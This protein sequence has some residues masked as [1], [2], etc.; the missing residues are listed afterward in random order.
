[1]TCK[2]LISLLLIVIPLLGFVPR[3]NSQSF[4]TIT[5]SNTLTS[6]ISTT[7]A[8]VSASG[9]VFVTVATET[10]VY[11]NSFTMSGLGALGERFCNANYVGPIYETAGQELVGSISAIGFINFYIMNDK[12]FRAYKSG[13]SCMPSQAEGALYSDENI[14]SVPLH[15]TAPYNGNYYFLFTTTSANDVTVALNV[16]STVNSTTSYVEYVTL[17]NIIMKS[18]TETVAI[19]ETSQVSQQS[20]TQTGIDATQT[21]IILIGVGAVISLIVFTLHRRRRVRSTGN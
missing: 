15:W 14:G 20:P 9:T 18:A 11:A 21:L 3:V 4:T 6:V 8:S 5:A 2:R 13:R 1:M 12:Q 7:Q 16:G 10:T 17:S 19:T